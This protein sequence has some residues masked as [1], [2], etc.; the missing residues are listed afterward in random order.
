M[1]RT[2]DHRRRQTCPRKRKQTP[3][4]SAP[5]PPFCSVCQKPPHYKCPKCKLPYCS[6]ACCKEH[7]KTCQGTSIVQ[8]PEKRSHYLVPEEIKQLQGRE[9]SETELYSTRSKY[10]EMGEE[11]KVTDTMKR[12]LLDSDWLRKEL[13]DVG[14]QAICKHIRSTPNTTVTRN[15]TATRREQVLENYKDQNKNFRSFMDKLL[16]I[17]GVLERQDT[18]SLTDFLKLDSTEPAGLVMKSSSGRPTKPSLPTDSCTDDEGETSS[19]ESISEEDESSSDSES[20]SS[21]D[22]GELSVS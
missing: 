1:K 18:G 15:S 12:S 4:S 16:V 6:V 9:Q 17:A 10:D 3:A 22:D 8:P 5:P 13:A 7:K 14:L 21:S 2:R 11:W 19:G 20:E